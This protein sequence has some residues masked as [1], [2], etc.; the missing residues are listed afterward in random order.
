[1]FEIPFFDFKPDFSYLSHLLFKN[2][3]FHVKIWTYKGVGSMRKVLLGH[4]ME[5]IKKEKPNLTEVELEQI[6]YGLTGIYLSVTKLIIISLLALWLGIL[7][8]CLCFTLIFA[9]IRTNAFGMHLTKSW[10]C[11]IASSIVFLGIPWLAMNITMPIWLKGILGIL[12]ILLIFKYSPADTHKRP[13]INP[14]KRLRH[15]ILATITAC[16]FTLISIFLKN[17]FLAN[18]FL[19]SLC[20]MCF[21]I[22]PITYRIFHLPYNNYLRY[23][24]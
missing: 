22:F 12:T 4:C 7:K 23:V 13:I 1:M 3:K 10:I 19:M 2:L 15:K 14:K 5:L 16:I 18:C 9:I 8:E 6:E 21:M 17:Q 11:L 24:S 20:L